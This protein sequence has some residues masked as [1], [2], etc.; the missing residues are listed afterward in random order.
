MPSFHLPLPLPLSVPFTDEVVIAKVSTGC[1]A[2]LCEQGAIAPDIGS[3]A[4]ATQGLEL[5]WLIRTSQQ[6]LPVLRMA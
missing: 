5:P 4:A 2:D 3:P 1:A 6:I